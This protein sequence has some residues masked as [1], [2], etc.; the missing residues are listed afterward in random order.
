VC[1]TTDAPRMSQPEFLRSSG[2]RVYYYPTAARKLIGP[3]GG[4]VMPQANTRSVLQ[5]TYSPVEVTD[6]DRQEDNVFTVRAWD[7][8]SYLRALRGAAIIN[9]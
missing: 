2:V 1:Y 9:P 7:K 4:R 6:T 3:Q 8:F 5:A